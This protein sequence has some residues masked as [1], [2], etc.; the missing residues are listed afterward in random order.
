M[1]NES[2]H[3]DK[4]SHSDFKSEWEARNRYKKIFR[5]SVSESTV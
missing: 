1:I 3:R 5:S 2:Y 4:A